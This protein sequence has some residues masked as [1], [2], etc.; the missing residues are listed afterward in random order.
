MPLPC[1]EICVLLKACFGSHHSASS[2][3]SLHC[4]VNL[5]PIL[6]FILVCFPISLKMMGFFFPSTLFF[7]PFIIS[8]SSSRYLEREQNAN[9]FIFPSLTKVSVSCSVM[10]NS[11]RLHGLQPLGSSVHEILQSRILEWVA[12][13]L[14]QGI[15]PTQGSNLGLL[16]C[17]QML[18][19]L[20]YKGILS[21]TKSLHFNY[22]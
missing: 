15:F 13:F 14:L 6:Q 7:N 1:E 2:F 17:R 18:Y 4:L 22:L 20:S 11:L 3:I 5:L 9:V 8:S 16:H 19:Q 10:P 12:I 21:I